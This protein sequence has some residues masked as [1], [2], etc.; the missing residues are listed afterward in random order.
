MA[1]RTV[2]IEDVERILALRSEINNLNL[3]DI[4]WTRN[5]NVIPV[6]KEAIDNWKFIGMTNTSFAELVL[7]EYD[8]VEE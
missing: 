7:V 5:D 6:T 3:E 2:A 4:V 8:E 1:N